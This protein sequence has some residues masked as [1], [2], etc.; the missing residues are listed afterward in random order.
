MPFLTKK[1]LHRYKTRG[2]FDSNVSDAQ[3]ANRH[4]HDQ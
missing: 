2:A 4:S 3:T 1:N